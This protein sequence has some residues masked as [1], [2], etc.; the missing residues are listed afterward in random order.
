M[1]N[2]DFRVIQTYAKTAG[3]DLPQ[4]MQEMLNQTLQKDKN[5]D[6]RIDIFENYGGKEKLIAK[7]NS[8]LQT[9]VNRLEGEGLFSRFYRRADKA[10]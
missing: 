2:I 5:L 6:G 8:T 10:Q 9:E 1:R 3:L 4:D 7:L